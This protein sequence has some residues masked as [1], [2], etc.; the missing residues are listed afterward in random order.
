MLNT[1][2]PLTDPRWQKYRE[3][4]CDQPVYYFNTL[5]YPESEEY[6]S[7]L[8]SKLNLEIANIDSQFTEKEIE[9]QTL[10]LEDQ[11]E[12]TAA[13]RKWRISAIRAQRMKYHQISFIQAWLL[14]AKSS[15]VDRI[16]SLEKR[17]EELELKLK[18]VK[19]V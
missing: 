5:P 15:Y 17:T 8:L 11:E 18:S 14:D 13:Y 3:T 1:D 9:L 6:A 10:P 16:S 2:Q 12:A 19:V 7:Q 4:F